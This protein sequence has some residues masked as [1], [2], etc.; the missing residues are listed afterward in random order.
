MKTRVTEAAWENG[1]WTVHADDGTAETFDFVLSA[2]G[3]LVEPRIPSI[4]GLESFGGRAFHS[5]QWEHDAVVEGRRVAVIGT[6][7]TGMQLIRGLA[8][9]A[10]YLELY[11]RTAQWV[12]PLPNRRTTRLGRWALRRFPRLERRAAA[13][14]QAAAE[15]V[16]GVATVQPGWQRMVMNAGCHAYLRTIR[17]PDLRR[18][19]TPKD[20]PMCKRLVLGTGFYKQFTRPDVELV[21]CPIETVT[22]DGIRTAD[23]RHH[24]LDVIV[25]ATG[26]HAQNYMRPMEIVGP[27]GVRLTELWTE[28][29][30]YAYRSVALPGFPN[31]FTLLGPHSPV[32]NQSLMDIAMTQADFV[33]GCIER[34]R[35]GEFDT[36]QPTAE[37]TDR[38]NVELREAIA[39]TIWASGCHSWYLAEDGVPAV[40]P[41]TPSRLREILHDL[42]PGDWEIERVPSEPVLAT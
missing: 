21:D 25:L 30:P 16:F 29:T 32:G 3:V 38:F 10:S 34:W 39:G 31:L 42:E 17:D 26:F 14:L 8:G 4:P 6:G 19:F 11:Q 23:G 27:G 40:F 2:T 37:A 36:L 18:R 7:S 5:A 9:V 1:A 41:W 33:I 20:A 24:P 35:T 15:V 13:N 28:H 12:F 22:P